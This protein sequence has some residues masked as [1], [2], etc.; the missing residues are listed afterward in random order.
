MTFEGL[1]EGD[2]EN[3]SQLDTDT[4]DQ[5]DGIELGV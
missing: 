5:G 3:P 4:V 1:E 2:D